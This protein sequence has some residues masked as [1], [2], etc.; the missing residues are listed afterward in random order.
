M[1][2]RALVRVRNLNSLIVRS[3]TIIPCVLTRD[4]SLLSRKT[5]VLN[6]HLQKVNNIQIRSKYDKKKSPSREDEVGNQLSEI[7][8]KFL[9]PNILLGFR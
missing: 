8:L 9:E 7:T 5:E 2:L 1:A 6:C 4:F 3:A